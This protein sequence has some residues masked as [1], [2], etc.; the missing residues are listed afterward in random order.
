MPGAK[1]PVTLLPD[2]QVPLGELGDDGAVTSDGQV[3]VALLL[4]LT[5]PDAQIGKVMMDAA[6]MALF[7]VADTKLHLTPYDTQGTPQG[8]AKAAEQAM[9][10]GAQLVLG[11]LFSTSVEQVKPITRAY[12]VNLIGFSNNRLVAGDGAYL[13]GLM[14]REQIGRIVGYAAQQGVRRFATLV[15]ETPYGEQVIEDL[16]DAVNRVGGVITKVQTY[17]A[18]TRDLSAAVRQLAD[19]HARQVIL[20]RRKAALR[21]VGSAAAKREL[22]ELDKLDTLGDLN[23]DALLLPQNSAQLKIIASLLPFYDI[24][25]AH[26]RLLGMTAWHNQDL[27]SEQALIGAWYPAPQIEAQIQFNKRFSAM[28][29]YEAPMLAMLAYDASALASVLGRAEG[30]PDFS[31]AAITNPNG[32]A[33]TAGIFRFLANGQAQ[34]SL[35]VMEVRKERVRILSPAPKTFQDLAF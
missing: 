33:G 20:E 32:Y 9:A 29:G 2:E 19:Y 24:D 34:R 28:Y 1:P 12:G 25:T 18:D 26:V 17:P 30:G 31:A 22:A 5:G 7:D 16:Q 14:P 10:D 8:A 21:R 11:P 4:P 23:Y 3:R 15:P 13:I 6:V 27:A 35:A